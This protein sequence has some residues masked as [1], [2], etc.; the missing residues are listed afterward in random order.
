[1]S[2]RICA[3]HGVWERTTDTKKCPQCSI[4]SH[5][6]YDSTNRNH[7]AKRFYNSAKWKMAR[8]KVINR[9]GGICQQCKREGRTE[10]FNVVDHIKEIS[11]GGSLTDKDN[12]E[13][14]CHSCHNKKT[15]AHAKVRK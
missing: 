11:D 9:D 2:K 10:L 6:T 14:L 13:C 12:L 3:K 1:M 15:A 8:E 4:A 7:E 5:K